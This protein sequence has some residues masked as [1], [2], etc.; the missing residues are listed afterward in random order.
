[1]QTYTTETESDYKGGVGIER[2]LQVQRLLVM[3]GIEYSAENSKSI[4]VI[5]PWD[6]S[7]KGIGIEA[8]KWADSKNHVTRSQT[9][10][11][12]VISDQ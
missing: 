7:S 3:K 1:M 4:H 10:A 9:I 2:E 8:G 5:K 12:W 11:E 6:G